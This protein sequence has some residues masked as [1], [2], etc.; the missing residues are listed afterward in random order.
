MWVIIRSVFLVGCRK[1]L[2]YD[3]IARTRRRL[4]FF[5]KGGTLI[6]ILIAGTRGRSLRSYTAYHNDSDARPFT[7]FYNSFVNPN[8]SQTMY[9]RI[10]ARDSFM[11]TYNSIFLYRYIGCNTVM[12]SA[13]RQ[14]APTTPPITLSHLPSL[15]FPSFQIPFSPHSFDYL[16]KKVFEKIGMIF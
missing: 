16:K 7:L 9:S 8:T 12:F 3:G 11:H 15:A 4:V 5:I 14:S 13:P 2:I 1:L 10:P 6:L